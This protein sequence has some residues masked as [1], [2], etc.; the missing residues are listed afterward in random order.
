MAVCVGTFAATALPTVTDSK[1]NTYT[2]RSGDLGTSCYIYEAPIT[3]ALLAGDTITVAAAGSTSIGCAALRISDALDASRV[4]RSSTSGISASVTA[5][6]YNLGYEWWTNSTVIAASFE[7]AYRASTP[8]S[9]WTE[10][11]DLSVNAGAKGL[12]VMSR[13]FSAIANVTVE[14]TLA[15]ATQT[16]IA[17][18][19]FRRATGSLSRD[20][21]A[22]RSRDHSTFNV[23]SSQTF[24]NVLSRDRS[25]HFARAGAPASSSYGQGWP[26]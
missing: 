21:Q 13:E 1:G 14:H 4:G 12:I 24:K 2:R 22:T 6:S 18:A 25:G 10:H 23:R 7:G 16:W 11:Y 26:R 5:H 8:G 3:V 9:G 20:Y 17:A 15:T 19:A